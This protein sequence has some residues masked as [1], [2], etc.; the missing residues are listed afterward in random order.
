[1]FKFI[2]SLQ[3]CPYALMSKAKGQMTFDECRYFK[4]KNNPRSNR[5]FSMTQIY[6]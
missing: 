6:Y 2:L 1:M 4:V 5:R 3:N